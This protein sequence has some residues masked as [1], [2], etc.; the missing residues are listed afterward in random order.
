MKITCCKDCKE[1]HP[2]CWDSCEKYKAEKAANDSLKAKIRKEKD[3]DYNLEN[4]RF[5]AI[6]KIKE[7]GRKHK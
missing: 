7:E 1:R 4:Q 6:K 5:I 3:R 2:A